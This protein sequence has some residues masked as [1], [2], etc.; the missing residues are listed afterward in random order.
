MPSMSYC[1]F[2]NTDKDLDQ[3]LEIMQE[4]SSLKEL[5]ESRSSSYESRA[6]SNVLET[7]QEIGEIYQ[8]WIE[9]DESE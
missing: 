1:V 8:Q 9:E 6:V 3:I 4:F 5:K 7:C 2:E